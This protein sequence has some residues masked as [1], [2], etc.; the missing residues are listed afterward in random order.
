MQW[1]TWRCAVKLITSQKGAAEKEQD[2][3]LMMTGISDVLME[4][5]WLPGALMGTKVG[6]T[7]VCL[8]VDYV[9]LLQSWCWCPES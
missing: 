4:Q 3:V 8:V 6:H 9:A 5:S 7:P 2:G 1:E